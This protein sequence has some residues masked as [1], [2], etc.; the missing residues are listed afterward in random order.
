MVSNAE[1]YSW[2][3]VDIDTKIDYCDRLIIS[4]ALVLDKNAGNPN[5]NG[6]YL[7]ASTYRTDIDVRSTGNSETDFAIK[8][9]EI[10]NDSLSTTGTSIYDY[11]PVNRSASS[12]NVTISLPWGISYN[13]NPESRVEIAKT[14]GGIGTYNL[15]TKFTVKFL[16]LQGYEIYGMYNENG[17]V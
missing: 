3:S 7:F 14:S 1:S 10:L 15:K 9:N 16:F 12:G 13:Y 5:G 11:D 8:S 4:S 17:L 6:Q 2:N